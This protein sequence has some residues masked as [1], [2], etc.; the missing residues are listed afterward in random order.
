MN[1]IGYVEGNATLK[2]KGEVIGHGIFPALEN[3]GS[4]RIE[5]MDVIIATY[6]KGALPK[7]LQFQNSNNKKNKSLNLNLLL[8]IPLKMKTWLYNKKVY[9]KVSRN[10][11]I[12]SIAN[13]IKVLSQK[14]NVQK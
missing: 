4:R 10:F 7:E 11:E 1:D 3:E 14:C 9:V 12:I 13:N 2:Y 6:S 8:S 5:S